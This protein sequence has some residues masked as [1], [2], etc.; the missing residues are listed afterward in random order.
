MSSRNIKLTVQTSVNNFMMT[1]ETISG[2]SKNEMLDLCVIMIK[3]L[4]L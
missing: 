4:S 2:D 1:Q 3:F